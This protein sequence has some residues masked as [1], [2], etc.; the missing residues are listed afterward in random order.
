[1]NHFILSRRPNFFNEK[2]QKLSTNELGYSSESQNKI[3]SKN[4]IKLG[5]C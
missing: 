1:M 4:S 3:K 5:P 2:K